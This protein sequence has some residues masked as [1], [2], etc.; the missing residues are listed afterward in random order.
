MCISWLDG[1]RL[2][3]DGTDVVS[4]YGFN[5][6]WKTILEKYVSVLTAKTEAQIIKFLVL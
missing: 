3:V 4:S 2:R 1:W 6:N 5:M